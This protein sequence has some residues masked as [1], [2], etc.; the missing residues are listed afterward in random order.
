MVSP[1]DIANISLDSIGSRFS[2][3]SLDPPLPAPNAIT[4]ARQYAL[5]FQTLARAAHWNCLRKQSPNLTVLKAAQGTPENP[6]GSGP[7]P[8]PP[9]Q[10]E[11]A[12]PADCIKA[13]YLVPNPPTGQGSVNPPFL[14]A[15]FLA[16]PQWGARY[17]G[18]PYAVGIDN[19]QSGNPVKVIFTDLE[20]AQVV[21]TAD[22]SNH[23]ELWDAHF[24]T[25]F[26]ET[27]A[28]WLVNALNRNAELMKEKIQTA[29]ALIQQARISDGN[30]GTTDITHVP[31]WMAARGFTGLGTFADGYPGQ[32]ASW[33]PMGWPTGLL[34]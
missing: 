19:D 3:T 30:E 5:R 6:D 32:Y 2:V 29:G 33:E 8:P 1:V 12:Y 15:G 27:L 9:F 18:W 4:V 24:T 17:G 20:F 10:Y 34:T 13:R 11:Y 23:T 7:Q 31:S 25:A 16:T 14:A 26:T 21:Y 22:F 28:A